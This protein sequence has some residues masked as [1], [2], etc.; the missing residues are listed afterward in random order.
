MAG[1]G[2][3]GVESRGIALNKRMTDGIISATGSSDDASISCGHTGGIV[4]RSPLH[5]ARGVEGDHD[6]AIYGAHV[7]A[8]LDLEN[9]SDRA[10]GLIASDVPNDIRSQRAAR[11]ARQVVVHRTD[12]VRCEAVALFDGLP[13]EQ[14]TLIRVGDLLGVVEKDPGA[15]LGLLLLV[16]GRPNR[17]DAGLNCKVCWWS[18]KR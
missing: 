3:A 17:W 11:D 14:R 12:A 13:T 6:A 18:S 7:G 1:G 16:A 8:I 4:R 15:I 10:I 5:I 9:W 2:A